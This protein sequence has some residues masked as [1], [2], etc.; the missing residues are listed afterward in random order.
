MN[1]EKNLLSDVSFQEILPCDIHQQ[2]IYSNPQQAYYSDIHAQRQN[3]SGGVLG[4]AAL[5]FIGGGTVGYFKNVAYSIGNT[6]KF[7]YPDDEKKWSAI[8]YVNREQFAIEFGDNAPV[9]YDELT[10]ANGYM[11]VSYD[12]NDTTFDSA[13][14][15]SIVVNNGFQ[16]IE[17]KKKKGMSLEEIEKEDEIRDFPIDYHYQFEENQ[18]WYGGFGYTV[19]QTLDYYQAHDSELYG[20]SGVYGSYSCD[21]VDDKDYPALM[22]WVENNPD[23]E[24]DE[25]QNFY[26]QRKKLR[27]MISAIEIGVMFL[28]V[29]IALIAIVNMVNIL[30]TGILNRKSELASMQCLGMTEGQLYGMTSIECAQYALISGVT[31]S[32]LSFAV[33]FLT[34]HFVE[35]IGAEEFYQG[36][37][38]L[39]YT[40]PLPRIWICAGVAFAVALIA[41][42]I[43]LKN[44]QKESFSEQVRS[45]D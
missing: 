7:I 14:S 5:G 25:Y 44:M 43:P 20:N 23:I 37:G 41:S 1:H 30:S 24:M 13:D 11:L 19:V 28:N 17:E 9:T 3:K 2:Q 35:L 34:E 12:P 42:F 40:M 33:I 15:V 8:D 31:A 45:V 4:A 27:T 29:M 26:L 6:R 36:V 32:L 38:K 16:E 21:I 22:A 10:K 39:S 18:M